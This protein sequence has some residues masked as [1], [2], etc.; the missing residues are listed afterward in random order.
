MRIFTAP[1]NSEVEVARNVHDLVK[2][3]G[4]GKGKDVKV[5]CWLVRP[6]V[7]SSVR[8]MWTTAAWHRRCHQAKRK[9]AAFFVDCICR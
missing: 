3:L 5:R 2:V 8:G 9:T 4:P 1:L 7:T 6:F